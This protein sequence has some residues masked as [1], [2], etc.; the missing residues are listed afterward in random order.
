MLEIF[1][2]N[3]FKFLFFILVYTTC[4]NIM[5]IIW[6]KINVITILY[7]HITGN[8]YLLEI[9]KIQVI[10]IEKKCQHYTK[11]LTITPSYLLFHCYPS[12]D[13]FV[14]GVKQC[15]L[16][17]ILSHFIYCLSLRCPLSLYCPYITWIPRHLK[18]FTNNGGKIAPQKKLVS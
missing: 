3:T 5:F 2:P 4:C 6:K 15:F 12:P 18:T 13:H 11:F 16:F 7:R 10:L 17:L 8:K 1:V 14:T 9:R